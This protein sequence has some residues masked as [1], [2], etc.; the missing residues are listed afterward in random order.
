MNNKVDANKIPHDAVRAYYVKATAMCIESAIRD[1]IRVIADE[2]AHEVIKDLGDIHSK[3]RV[4][5]VD[6]SGTLLFSIDIRG[7]DEKT[8]E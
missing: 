1:K 8:D 2:I 5:S 3:I 7:K 6:D 4:L